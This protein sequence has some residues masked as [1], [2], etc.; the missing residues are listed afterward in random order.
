MYFLWL[1]RDYCTKF[2]SDLLAFFFYF[3]RF[4]FITFLHWSTDISLSL[5]GLLIIISE[6]HLPQFVCQVLI[7]G[8][9]IIIPLNMARG[10]NI[11]I[12]CICILWLKYSYVLH[13]GLNL[14]FFHFCNDKCMVGD[15]IAIIGK[16]F[17]W[18]HYLLSSILQ[19]NTERLLFI[20][21]MPCVLVLLSKITVFTSGLVILLV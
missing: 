20:L 7:F 5:Q 12:V 18:S 9:F 17:L 13:W 10:S 1:V 11:Q 3:I 4:L 19:M 15:V 21:R 2:E 14:G 16:C 6:R 8:I